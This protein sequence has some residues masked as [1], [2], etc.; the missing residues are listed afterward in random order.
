MRG[1][2]TTRNRDEVEE[3]NRTPAAPPGKSR[4]LVLQ[5]ER[6]RNQEQRRQSCYHY[7]CP[8][9]PNHEE[10]REEQMKTTEVEHA[11]M[12]HLERYREVAEQSEGPEQPRTEAERTPHR[13]PV[14][15]GAEP[16]KRRRTA[17]P[18]QGQQ[19]RKSPPN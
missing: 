10:S 7:R 2:T 16:A 18:N 11:R 13:G 1:Q 5:V 15:A 6:Q 12:T 4:I 17:K 8:R 19:V 9:T 3:R 14:E